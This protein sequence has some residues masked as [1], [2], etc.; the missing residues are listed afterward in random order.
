[1][2]SDAMHWQPSP[3]HCCT[4]HCSSS[5]G[6][7]Q[8]QLC[9]LRGSMQPSKGQKDASSP[10]CKAPL[11]SPTMIRS[12]KCKNFPIQL[13]HSFSPCLTHS[14]CRRFKVNH[15]SSLCKPPA[16]I[17]QKVCAHSSDLAVGTQDY[18]LGITAFRHVAPPHGAGEPPPLHM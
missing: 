1:M 12:P 13:S 2:C 7:D 4:L 3:M 6:P 16:H 17:R 15:S 14:A 9:G 10:E 5:G 8:L 11:E 18:A